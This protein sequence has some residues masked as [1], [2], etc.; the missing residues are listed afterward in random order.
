MKLAPK[1]F[2]LGY[3]ILKTSDF[4]LD[5]ILLYIRLQKTAYISKQYMVLVTPS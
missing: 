2:Y 4:L 3:F 5:T 1:H